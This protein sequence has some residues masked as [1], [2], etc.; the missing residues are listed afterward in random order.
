MALDYVHT[1]NIIHRDIKSS[2]IFLTA[3]GNVKLG[4]FGIARILQNTGDKATTIVGTPFYLS[5]EVC[6]S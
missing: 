1:R 5:P 3:N 6:S 4:D 2:N